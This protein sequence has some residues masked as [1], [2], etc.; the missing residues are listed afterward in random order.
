MGA[1]RIEVTKVEAEVG[2]ATGVVGADI[3]IEAADIALTTGDLSRVAGTIALSG[4]PVKV[5]KQSFG[6]SLGIDVVALVLAFTGGIGPITGAV[7]SIKS[8]Q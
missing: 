6:I 5:I 8:A 1:L 3:A 7:S 4:Q 2:I